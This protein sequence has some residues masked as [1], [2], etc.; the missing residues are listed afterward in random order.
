MEPSEFKCEGDC[1]NC[2]LNRCNYSCENCDLAP[3]NFDG[4]PGVYSDDRCM[5]GDGCLIRIPLERI[6]KLQAEMKIIKWYQMSPAHPLTCGKDSNH[7]LEPVIEGR[8]V[9]LKCPQCDYTQQFIP[10]VVYE[11][12]YQSLKNRR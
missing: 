5:Q 1:P 12:Y 10:S 8:F 9:I 2:I 11:Y 4:Y 7:I 3:P 6:S